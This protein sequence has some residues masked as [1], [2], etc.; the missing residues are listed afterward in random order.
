MA[1]QPLVPGD[2][3]KVLGEDY[4]KRSESAVRGQNHFPQTAR[5]NDNIRNQQDYKEHDISETQAW[6][7]A[8]KRRPTKKINLPYV[9]P[10]FDDDSYSKHKIGL[11]V[12]EWPQT[13]YRP[14]SKHVQPTSSLGLP[15]QEPKLKT[16]Q[17]SSIEKHRKTNEIDH[18]KGKYTNIHNGTYMIYTYISYTNFQTYLYIHNICTLSI[19]KSIYM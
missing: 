16:A 5:I 11:H 3:G 19:H 13:T 1:P 10:H 17:R 14:L 7:E 12:S 2:V 6:W 8:L 15:A 9:G 4:P 18:K